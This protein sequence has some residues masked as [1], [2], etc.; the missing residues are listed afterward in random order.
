MG[1]YGWG[2]GAGTLGPVPGSCLAAAEGSGAGQGL[3]PNHT[4]LPSRAM[5]IL[6]KSLTSLSIQWVK[7]EH[8]A[9]EFRVQD[10]EI[11]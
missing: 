8:R 6:A 11:S 1:Q 4:K 2:G 3:V 9:D 7:T 10:A 5:G